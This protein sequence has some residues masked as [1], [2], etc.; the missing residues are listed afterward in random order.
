[1]NYG[2][3]Q[4]EEGSDRTRGPCLYVR[5]T[6]HKDRA[7][8]QAAFTALDSSLSS[9]RPQGPLTGGSE[10]GGGALGTSCADYIDLCN[11]QARLQHFRPEMLLTGVNLSSVMSTDDHRRH[12]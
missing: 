4:C 5:M 10:K 7:I 11:R 8:V 9:I 2:R 3:T 1:M 6:E 12:V